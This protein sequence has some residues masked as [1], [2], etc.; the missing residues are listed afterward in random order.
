M[1]EDGIECESFTVISIHSICNGCH[2]L[3]MLCLN[4]SN[5][6][7]ITIKNVDYHCIIHNIFFY[8]FC[9]VYI[10][11][12]YKK[13]PYLIRYIPDQYKIQ[14]KCDKAILENRR[15]LESLLQ[16]SRNE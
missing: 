7:I 11:W 4:I 10:K 8:F 2:D 9:L 12:F 16:N 5:I 3:S 14:Q 15:T 6:A 1:P 13:L